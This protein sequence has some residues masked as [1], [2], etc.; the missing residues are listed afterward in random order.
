MCYWL[1]CCPFGVD[2]PGQLLGIN[3]AANL[4]AARYAAAFGT[5]CTCFSVA[6]AID[7]DRFELKI[8][9][10]DERT[11]RIASVER[12]V[13]S[14]AGNRPPAVAHQFQ[15]IAERS[16]IGRGGKMKTRITSSLAVALAASAVRA[17]EVESRVAK[18]PDLV[19][20]EASITYMKDFDVLVSEQR[21]R[22]I[23]SRTKPEA[24]GK[25]DGAPV[26]GYVFHTTL[27]SQDVGFSATEG[28]MVLVVISHPGFG[29]SPFWDENNDGRY[30]NDDLGYHT[31][32]VESVEEALAN[33]REAR[34]SYLEEFPVPGG[35]QPLVANFQVAVSA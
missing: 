30:D 23:A 32:W 26:F 18:A 34:E 21:V 5:M 16:E 27:K 2:I 8:V 13:R 24:V 19:L 7:V 15:C 29:D 33:L 12:E 17:A 35:V 28:M 9:Q 31:H 6:R 25:L 3:K 14:G 4:I 1:R 22:G 20:T 11:A 10:L